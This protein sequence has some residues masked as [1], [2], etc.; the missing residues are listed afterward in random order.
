[1][2]SVH[3]ASPGATFHH[4]P[5]V[6]ARPG[7]LGARSRASDSPPPATCHLLRGAH[8]PERPVRGASSRSR[9]VYS[10]PAACPASAL[11]WLMNRYGAL[12]FMSAYAEHD[13]LVL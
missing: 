2:R 9:S 12:A 7:T 8:G 1:M 11:R 3:R 5:A 13:P 6:A 10:R 4:L